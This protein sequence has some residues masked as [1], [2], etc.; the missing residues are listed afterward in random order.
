MRRRRLVLTKCLQVIP[1]CLLHLIVLDSVET[2]EKTNSK[3]RSHRNNTPENGM[4][5]VRS[6]YNTVIFLLHTSCNIQTQIQICSFKVIVYNIY[7]KNTNGIMIST[8]IRIS[9]SIRLINGAPV[10][11]T[12]R[13][14]KL[15]G[16]KAR[17]WHKVI[18]TTFRDVNVIAI[19]N[20]QHIGMKSPPTNR[21]KGCCI[22]ACF[23]NRNKYMDIYK[24]YLIIRLYSFFLQ[25]I[26]DN[27]G[28]S[29]LVS[30]IY[31][32]TK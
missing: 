22:V 20:F 31:H 4:Y 32:H 14:L 3:H 25:Y 23:F 17:A 16:Y 13:T 26:S 18:S 30:M 6:R 19:K 2:F 15:N 7:T 11:V 10:K 24:W 27:I 9:F 21:T 5:S 8:W 1:W 12:N 29:V 28:Q